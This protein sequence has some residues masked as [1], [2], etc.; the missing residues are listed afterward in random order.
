MLRCR[1]ELSLID[2]LECDKR[3]ALFAGRRRFP[4]KVVLNVSSEH[5]DDGSDVCWQTYP[6]IREF[7]VASLENPPAPNGGGT[8]MDL[9]KRA[10]FF[11]EFDEPREKPKPRTDCFL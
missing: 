4:V 3:F 10:K 2:T 6:L 8:A 1:C 9:D 11:K 7:D 5:D